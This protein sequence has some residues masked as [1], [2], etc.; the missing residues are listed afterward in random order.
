MLHSRRI[1]LLWCKEVKT[2]DHLIVRNLLLGLFCW[3]W[4]GAAGATS[5]GW[6]LQHDKSSFTGAGVRR[7]RGNQKGAKWLKIEI[8]RLFHPKWPKIIPNTIRASCQTKTEHFNPDKILSWH[9]ETLVIVKK[10][11][12]DKHMTLAGGLAEVAEIEEVAEALFAGGGGCR[13]QSNLCAFWRKLIAL[14]WCIDN[15]IDLHDGRVQPKQKI[16][17]KHRAIND[18]TL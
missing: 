9:Y 10:E 16:Q 18:I 11:N 5:L 13:R 7:G 1:F 17:A 4:A 12:N 3:P 8:V 6:R 14:H 15:Q 2:H